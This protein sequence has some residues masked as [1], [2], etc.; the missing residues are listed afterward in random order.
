MVAVTIKEFIIGITGVVIGAAI[1]GF[2]VFFVQKYFRREQYRFEVF[3]ERKRVYKDLLTILN[4]MGKVANRKINEADLIKYRNELYEIIY[5]NIPF[6]KPELFGLLSQYLIKFTLLRQAD[7]IESL[8][9]EKGIYETDTESLLSRIYFDIIDQIIKELSVQIL[10]DT[11]EFKK[12][13]SQKEDLYNELL[14]H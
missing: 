4:K 9:K 3:L 11:K 10:L 6:I 2:A 7:M 13:I 12:I 5:N 8:Q 14:K 1:S